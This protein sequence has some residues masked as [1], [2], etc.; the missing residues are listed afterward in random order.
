MQGIVDKAIVVIT[1][2]IVYWTLHSDFRRNLIHAGTAVFDGLVED[3]AAPK[4]S[5]P[6]GYNW[7]LREQVERRGYQYEEHRIETEDGY[8]LKA[9]RVPGK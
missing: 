3:V 6:E 7:T 8:I 2:F 1:N 5:Y 9:F 4:F